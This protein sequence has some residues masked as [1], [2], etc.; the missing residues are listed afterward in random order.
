M[1]ETS[2]EDLRAELARLEGEEAKLSAMRSRLQDQIDLGFES[3]TTRS[4]EREVSDERQEL[5]R[6]IDA[7][8]ARL[9]EQQTA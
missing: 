8:R 6:R 4:R 3:E 1:T 2:L 9:G 5:H 7:I